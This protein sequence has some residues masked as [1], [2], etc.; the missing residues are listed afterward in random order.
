MASNKKFFSHATIE[1]N[2]SI[3]IFLSIL[4]VSFS[5]LVQIVPLFYQHSTTK[6]APGVKP[7]NALQLV[8]RDVFIKEGCVGCHSQQVRVLASDV[9]RYG[10]Y[11][12]AGES[13]YEYPFLW[14]SRRMGPD[15]ARVGGRYSDDWH[16]IHL[17]DPR[18]VVKQSNMPAYYWLQHKDVSNT[19]IQNRMIAFNKLNQFHQGEPMYS[20][21]EIADAPNMI[22]GKTEEDAVI[23]YLQNL[24]V[25]YVTA[26]REQEIKNKQ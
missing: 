10:P 4:V 22:K 9:Q 2:L 12:V 13:V 26:L 17:R 24:G 19:N 25:G 20:E 16:R 14:G 3:L 6:A 8:G 11:S 18:M 7:L 5:G 23:A 1:K 15:L 21:K